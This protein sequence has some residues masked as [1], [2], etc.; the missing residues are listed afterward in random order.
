MRTASWS[1]LF[2]ALADDLDIELGYLYG[3]PGRLH[4]DPRTTAGL[5]GSRAPHVWLQQDGQRV[6]TIDLSGQYLLLAGPAGAAWQQAAAGAA[7]GF[8]GLRLDSYRIGQDAAAFGISAQGATLIRPD[9]FV[10]WRSIDGAAQPQ[11]A[12]QAAL[13]HSLGH[14]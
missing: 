6:S 1:W 4:A 11:R 2:E 8:G 14:T 9:G 5:P 13:A 7:S 12:L 10:A 3:V